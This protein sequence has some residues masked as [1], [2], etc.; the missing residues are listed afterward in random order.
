MT[1]VTSHPEMLNNGDSAHDR[2]ALAKRAQPS[3]VVL[4]RAERTTYDRRATAS[5]T[6]NGRQGGGSQLARIFI[7]DPNAIFRMGMVAYLGS[8]P[9]IGPV[10][11][12]SSPEEVWG[13]DEIEGAE[14]VIVDIA[15]G[16]VDMFIA[17][18]HQRLGR[19][20]LVIA[21]AWDREAVLEAVGANAIG[22]VCKDGLTAES[23]GIQVRAAMHGAGVV[24]PQLLTSL[25]NQGA[26]GTARRFPRLGLTSRECA[27][28]RLIADGRLTREVATELSYSERTVKTVLRD[29]AVKLGARS[30]SQAIASAVREGL[31]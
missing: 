18:V 30:R 6:G 16:H 20:V 9:G 27:V 14:L 25:V 19:P 26:E 22:V 1:I 13:T 21:D 5:D 17:Q 12:F 7:V 11:G 10:V 2:T 29:A 28:L 8:L 23:L 31:I 3:P 15:I 4:R 24:P